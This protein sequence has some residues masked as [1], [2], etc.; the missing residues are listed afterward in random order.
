MYNNTHHGILGCRNVGAP[1]RLLKFLMAC[2]QAFYLVPECLLVASTALILLR[3]TGLASPTSATPLSPWVIHHES[4]QEGKGE[5]L[6][7]SLQEGKGE[8][9]RV[10]LHEGRGRGLGYHCTKV[11]GGA[12]GVFLVGES[13][14]YFYSLHCCKALC[15]YATSSTTKC[16]L[17]YVSIICSSILLCT[18]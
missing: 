2:P 18:T 11:G 7:V 12:W 10:S 17:M 5:G 6:G 15:M 16:V 14:D 3:T 4:L 13:L 1:I 8:G 9:L